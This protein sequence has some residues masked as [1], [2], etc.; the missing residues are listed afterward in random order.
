MELTAQVAAVEK[1]LAEQLH[2]RNLT[3]DEW[4]TERTQLE[5][6][7]RSTEMRTEEALDVAST[8]EVQRF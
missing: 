2:A 6:A 8:L 7:L 1:Q 5:D 3:M 4:I